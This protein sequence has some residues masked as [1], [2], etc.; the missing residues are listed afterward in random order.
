MASFSPPLRLAFALAVLLSGVDTAAAG[1]WRFSP[2]LSQAG[3]W[4]DNALM[5]THD[6]IDLYGSV[7]KARLDITGRTPRSALSFDTTVEQNLFNETAFNSTDLHNASRLSLTTE[8]A[9]AALEIGG[10]YDT[11]R[12][13]EVSTFGTAAKAVRHGGY[14]A[15]PSLSWTLDAVNMLEVSSAY[16]ASRYDDN[17]Y[18]NHDVYD[19]D[20]TWS[21]ALT[22]SLRGLVL[23]HG[24]RYQSLDG[25]RERVDSVGPRAGF[26]LDLNERIQARLTVGAEASSRESTTTAQTPWEWGGV[27]SGSLRFQGEKDTLQTTASRS[28]QPYNNGSASLMTSLSAEETHRINAS[29]SLKAG[30]HYAWAKST[31]L[32]SSSLEGKWGANAGVVYRFLPDAAVDASYRYREETYRNTAAKARDNAGMLTLSY[33]PDWSAP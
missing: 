19:A 22:P 10:D 6:P 33:T 26:A 31:A 8:G 16:A 13:S 12:T 21:Y 11:T 28:Q 9:E 14:R 17:V 30:G 25:T 1:E 23:A 7:T 2:A 5:R 20:A 3:L 27:F 24:R 29:L 18:A 32:S 4:E 15:S